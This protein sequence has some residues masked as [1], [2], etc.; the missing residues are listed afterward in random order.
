MEQFV[1]FQKQMKDH[2]PALKIN[3]KT[4]DMSNDEIIKSKY[5]FYDENIE[6]RDVELDGKQ[7]QHLMDAARRDE[8]IACLVWIKR[9][10]YHKDGSWHIYK[11]MSGE[12]YT[13]EQLYQLFK[14]TI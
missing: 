6:Q 2:A 8:A 9:N 1:L 5:P 14:Q 11:G 13:E 4:T 3:L 12:I 10:A 7:V